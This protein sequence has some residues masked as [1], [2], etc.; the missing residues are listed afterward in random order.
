VRDIGVIG[1]GLMGS[2]IA[3]VCARAGSEVVVV[4]A[5]AGSLAAGRLRI[6]RSLGR[7][8]DRGRI[9]PA[10]RDGTLAR[11]SGATDVAAVA[12]RELVI[13]AVVEDEA[14]K[15]DVLRRLDGVVGPDAILATNTSALAIGRLGAATGR[16]DRVVG[17]HFFNPAPARPLVEVVPS[18]LTRPDVVERVVA[19]AGDRLGKRVVRAPDRAGFIV[20][21][22]LVPY[23]LCAIRMLESG[24]ASAV[25][26]DAAMVGG[27]G[28]PMGPLALADLIGLDT[29]LAMARTLYGELGGEHHLAPPLLVRMVEAGHLGQKSGQGFHRHRA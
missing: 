25:D 26:I 24:L 4:E 14:V 12:D 1:C 23:L 29:T 11:I 16:P 19:Y 17:L 3:E 27:C 20:N 6:E 21:A 28:H 10:E 22:L 9:T 7:S 8:V 15:V 2:G 5:D 13:E 18:L